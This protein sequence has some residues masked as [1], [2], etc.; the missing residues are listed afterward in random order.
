MKNM[1][2]FE[3]RFKQNIHTILS[4]GVYLCFALIVY[5]Q[6]HNHMHHNLGDEEDKYYRIATVA[7]PD[8]IKLEVSGMAELPD[9]RLAVSTRMGE[10][11]IIENATMENNSKPIFKLFAS[12]L[13][14]P[15]GLAYRDKAFFVAQRA[16][17]TKITDTNGD[18]IADKFETITTWPLSGNYCEYNHGPILPPDGNFYINFNLGDNG[19]GASSE[20]FYGEMGS[21]AAWRGW[22]VQVTPEGKLNP[23]AA[24]LRSPAGIGVN[25]IGDVFYTENQGGWVGTGYLSHVEKGDFFGHPSSLKSA[26]LPGSP[27]KIDTSQ[28]PRDKPLLHEMVDRLPGFKMPSVRFPHGILGTSLTGFVPDTTNGKFGP[29]TD[30]LFVGDEGQAN[31]MRVFLEK[32]NGAY[33]GAVFPF[34]KGFESGILRM[35]CAS[36]NSIYVGMS[37]R[38]WHSS[39]PKRY[40]LQRLIWTEEIPFEI[41]TIKAQS[42]GFE[43]EFTMPINEKTAIDPNNYQIT[44]FDYAYQQKYGSDLYEKKEG[45][46]KAVKISNSGKNVRIVLDE[47]RKGFIYEIKC[48][49]IKSAK[50]NPL[51][52]DFGFYSLNNIP[53]GNPLTLDDSVTQFHDVEIEEKTVKKTPKKQVVKQA[54]NQRISTKTSSL[55][56]NQN[57]VPA[58]WVNG[59]DITI[60]IGVKPGLKY[61]LENFNIKPNAKVKLELVNTDDMQHNLVGTLPKSADKVGKTA[62]ILGIDGTAKNW[63]P[64][65][66]EVLFHTKIVQP[67][68][69]EVIYF[70]APAAEG[71]YEYVCTYPGHYMSMRGV[72]KVYK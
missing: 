43:L 25:S 16:E 59:P 14:T 71:D 24:G 68:A 12:G 64:D 20:P 39:G 46:I 56:K 11:W 61:D 52:H 26:N 49:G 4:V 63:V 8:S 31:I 22:M 69:T 17:L 41:K 6:D 40:G 50:G 23:Y 47:L 36:D 35:N 65:L 45:K 5:G 72:M 44:S 1:N 34:K 55:K 42:D 28:V 18:D 7:I 10:L 32:V 62:L 29:F 66:K 51:L 57:S 70:V 53:I 37:D 2:F 60:T 9:Q 15:L 30:Q 54:N 19:M 27:V 48:S 67:G 21:H 3:F 38:G 33:Q 58:D 13:H